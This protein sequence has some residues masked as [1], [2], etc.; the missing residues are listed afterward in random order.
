MCLLCGWFSSCT[1][2]TSFSFIQSFHLFDLK[3]TFTSHF[4]HI[5]EKLCWNCEQIISFFYLSW[6]ATRLFLFSTALFITHAHTETEFTIQLHGI[7]YWLRLISINI[8]LWCI[9]MSL[10]WMNILQIAWCV[11]NWAEQRY[12]RYSDDVEFRVE[13]LPS[14]HRRPGKYAFIQTLSHLIFIWSERYVKGWR[15]K[16]AVQLQHRQRVIATKAK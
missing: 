5:T 6:D 14:S 13:A 3:S 16:H 9:W 1:R 10:R 2:I 4:D 8:L 15:I 12:G 7:V 11:F